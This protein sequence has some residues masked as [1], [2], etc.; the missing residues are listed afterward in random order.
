[1]SLSFHIIGVKIK[2][3]VIIVKEISFLSGLKC[4]RSK[5]QNVGEN[6]ENNDSVINVYQLGSMHDNAHFLEIY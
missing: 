4:C 1:M 5:E 6:L 3:S 2:V